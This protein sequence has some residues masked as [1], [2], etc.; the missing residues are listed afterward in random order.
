M[1][2]FNYDSFCGAG[3]NCISDIKQP[4]EKM[5]SSDV[6]GFPYSA[7]NVTVDNAIVLYI[8]CNTGDR[9]SNML[10]RACIRKLGFLFSFTVRDCSDFLFCYFF[11]GMPGFILK[12]RRVDF[13]TAQECE[14]KTVHKNIDNSCIISALVL[15]KYSL[16]R[17]YMER[18]STT[19]M[20]LSF[21][22]YQQ[23]RHVECKQ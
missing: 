8:S 18:I 17:C 5:I 22:S 23:E 11:Q 20:I 16:L 3:V 2:A 14:F 6:Q 10:D 15:L 9:S 12:Q 4:E 1:S 13:L 7:N 21:Q 19:H